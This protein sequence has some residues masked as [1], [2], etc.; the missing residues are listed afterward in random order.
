[1][2]ELIISISDTSLATK[3][4]AQIVFELDRK[5]TGEQLR[6]VRQAV[7]EAVKGR[8]REWEYRREE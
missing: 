1:M 5:L 7:K 4:Y 3:R 6:E 2:P 8:L